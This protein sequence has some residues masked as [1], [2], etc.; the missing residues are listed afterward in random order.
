MQEATTRGVVQKTSQQPA[1]RELSREDT[2]PRPR[3]FDTRKE[4]SIVSGQIVD[5]K[6]I[7]NRKSINQNKNCSSVT[8][9]L[10]KDSSLQ[11]KQQKKFTIF[12]NAPS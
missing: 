12:P 1:Q 2:L 7:Y 3:I 5:L 10:Q 9:D 8:V 4:P 11:F 6:Q